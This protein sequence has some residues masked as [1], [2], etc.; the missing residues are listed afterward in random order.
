MK[1]IKQGKEIGEILE[2]VLLAKLNGSINNI[3]EEYNFVKNVI[4][5]NYG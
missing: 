5:H 1:Q 4:E 2:I 3:Q